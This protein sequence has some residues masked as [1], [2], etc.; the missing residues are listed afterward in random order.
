MQGISQKNQEAVETT[1]TRLEGKLDRF[2]EEQG[3]REMMKQDQG[4]DEIPNE[5][6]EKA[7]T[8]IQ[9][10]SEDELDHFN[11]RRFG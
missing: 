11:N 6:P 7:S 3:E 8:L 1:T 2:Q 4:G 10:L 9:P 5:N